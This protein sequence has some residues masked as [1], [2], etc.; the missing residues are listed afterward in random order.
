MHAHVMDYTALSVHPVAKMG[1]CLQRLNSF[2]H[3]PE[4]E[5]WKAS[6]FTGMIELMRVII[7]AM[8]CIADLPNFAGS[9]CKRDLR[10]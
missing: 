4:L 9:P 6:L 5:L 10:E 8:P 1:G 7:E 3:A 2:P